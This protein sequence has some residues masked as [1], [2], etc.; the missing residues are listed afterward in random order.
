MLVQSEPVL[1]GVA[2]RYAARRIAN[3]WSGGAVQGYNEVPANEEAETGSCFKPANCNVSK[4]IVRPFPIPRTPFE[5]SGSH[6][7]KLRLQQS[8]MAIV[9]RKVP[10]KRSVRIPFCHFCPTGHTQSNEIWD[11]A[12]SMSQSPKGLCWTE[13][14]HR[15]WGFC[16]L[17][18]Q[19]GFRLTCW[20]SFTYQRRGAQPQKRHTHV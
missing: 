15:M 14:M 11:K 18:R 17:G 13:L 16:F 8:A 20:F 6:R 5:G 19:N 9:K 7:R 1:Q 4:S 12:P 10:G 2:E 3:L